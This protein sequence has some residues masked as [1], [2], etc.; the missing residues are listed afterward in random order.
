MFTI[1]P[2]CRHRQWPIELPRHPL[3]PHALSIVSDPRKCRVHAA[4]CHVPPSPNRRRPLQYSSFSPAVVLALLGFPF[5]RL[6][7]LLR[8][9]LLLL[10]LLSFFL[11]LYFFFFFFFFFFFVFFF[12]FFFVFVFF[13]FFCFFF[14]FLFSSSVSSSPS[15]SSSAS[16][17]TSSSCCDCSCCCCG[18]C[19]CYCGP[20][21]PA[22]PTACCC[23]CHRSWCC[24]CSGEQAEAYKLI[25]SGLETFVSRPR[26]VS[27]E[28]LV[29][30]TLSCK[31]F[32]SLPETNLSLAQTFV[33]GARS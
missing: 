33:S 3:L 13:F 5:L 12:F 15:S 8:L 28:T 20:A 17:S 11:L 4:A 27:F 9:L 25:F 23:R 32:F 1:I 2:L 16:S 14:F 30:I 7:F 18:W 29:P 31:R 22:A 21:A 10:L 6:P 26:N 24:C 19:Y